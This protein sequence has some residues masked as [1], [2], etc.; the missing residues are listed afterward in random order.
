MCRKAEKW[1]AE[2]MPAGQL[3]YHAADALTKTY[4]YPQDKK[5]SYVLTISAELE[6]KGIRLNNHISSS[7]GD[8]DKTE[9]AGC[10]VNISYDTQDTITFFSNGQGTIKLDSAQSIQKIV[11][12]ESAVK[13]VNKKLADF[14]KLKIE[15][16]IPLYVI[17]ST[18]GPAPNDYISSPGKAVEARPVYAF[19]FD[20][21]KENED[22]GLSKEYEHFAVV[23]METGELTTDF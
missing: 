17:Y 23:D 21:R 16:I 18:I 7:Y 4:L 10:D 2:K 9:I 19:L 15:K 8:D 20:K 11:D 6:Y 3:T 22:L 12:F 5:E 13:L 1:L 14:N